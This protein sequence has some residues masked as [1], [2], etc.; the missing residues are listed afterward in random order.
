MSEFHLADFLPYQLAV[1]SERISQRLAVEY[2]RSHGLSVA[3]WRILAHLYRGG[4]VSV[5]DLQTVTNLEKS[6]ISRAVSR[7]QASGLVHKRA[8]RS[9]GRLVA[10]E[11]TDKGGQVMEE[12]L[13]SALAFERHLL[14]GIPADDLR[15]FLRIAEHLHQV[16][17]PDP[18]AKPRV[19]A[20]D[21]G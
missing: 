11:L 7:L 18:D 17:D 3:E 5:R 9:D 4:P 6:R 15:R 2:G 12:I 21:F 14:A 13:P 20:E 8:E 19:K 1:L 10:I 16:L